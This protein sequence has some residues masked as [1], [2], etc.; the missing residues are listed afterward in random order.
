[1]NASFI[2]SILQFVMHYLLPPPLIQPSLVT[3]FNNKAHPSVA[4]VT[5]AD[6]YPDYTIVHACYYKTAFEAC[7]SNKNPVSWHHMHGGHS[8]HMY[9]YNTSCI[10]SLLLLHM[11]CGLQWVYFPL[12]LP[13]VATKQTTGTL[14][15]HVWY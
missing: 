13:S 4:H 3:Y 14:P 10:N 8:H 1:M 9:L 2:K 11:W 15:C 6:S 5:H 12:I 7:I